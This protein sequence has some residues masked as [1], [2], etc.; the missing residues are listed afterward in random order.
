[1]FLTEEQAKKLL[2]TIRA[3]YPAAFKN[4][5]RQ[6]ALDMVANWQSLEPYEA[7]LTI[8]HDWISV[9]KFPPKLADIGRLLDAARTMPS[10]EELQSMARNR[11]RQME[12][13]RKSAEDIKAFRE[14]WRD[15]L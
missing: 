13:M 12:R 15:S 14:K 8:V 9:S 5:K 10:R 7:V 4:L 2:K 1:M 6:E 3:A 11:L